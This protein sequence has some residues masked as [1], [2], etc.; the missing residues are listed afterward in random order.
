VITEEVSPPTFFRSSRRA[1]HDDK[2][3]LLLQD[4]EHPGDWRVEYFGE[5]AECYVMI[6]SAR[7]RGNALASIA[8]P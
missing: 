4:R 6:F 5:D 8:A 2:R 7:W 1:A 3:V